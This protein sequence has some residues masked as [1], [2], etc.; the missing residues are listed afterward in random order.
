MFK[1]WFVTI[2]ENR[3]D[4]CN[5]YLCPRFRALSVC[6]RHSPP[7]WLVAF[8]CVG[9]CVVEQLLNNETVTV[10][11]SSAA[12]D[13]SDDST[14]AVVYIDEEFDASWTPNPTIHIPGG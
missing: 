11:G 3:V 8:L 13:W 2:L 5:V 10:M 9:S 14:E 4:M 7:R 12:C 6:D 1:C